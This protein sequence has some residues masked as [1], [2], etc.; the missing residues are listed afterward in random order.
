[1]EEG[2]EVGSD[3][4]RRDWRALLTS[5]QYGRAHITITRYGGP[6]A[7]LVPVD[8]YEQAHARLSEGNNGDD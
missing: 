5:V 1:M 6:A 7:V 8:W 4:A 3:G 2:R